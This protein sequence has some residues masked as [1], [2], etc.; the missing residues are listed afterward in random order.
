[1]TTSLRRDL[2]SDFDFSPPMGMMLIMHYNIEHIDDLEIYRSIFAVTSTQNF[3]DQDSTEAHRSSEPD[4]WRSAFCITKLSI[5]SA[6]NPLELK[7][8]CIATRFP[9]GLS[10]SSCEEFVS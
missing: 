10:V 4:S 1:M 8:N 5:V 2:G 9:N 3:L 7:C 6:F